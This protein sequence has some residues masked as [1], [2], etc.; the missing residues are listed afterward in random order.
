[1]TSELQA[2]AD[3][4]AAAAAA[5]YE[6]ALAAAHRLRAARLAGDAHSLDAYP[7]GQVPLSAL[8]MPAFDRSVHLRCD[9]A[10]LLDGLNQAFRAEFGH[11][12]VVSDSYR[13]LDQQV[14]CTARKGPLCAEPGTSRHGRGVA[15]DLGGA[16][17]AL[18]TE[19]HQWLLDNGP[20]FGWV[21]PTW[22]L[23]TGSKP[24]SWHFEFDGC[25]TS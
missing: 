17:A 8:C 5:Q 18:G 2:A 19:E 21:K 13:S 1:V 16:G 6:E 9:A 10:E 24:E 4:A 11:D 23:P 20:E 25:P 14:A 12:L 3:E 15:V 22:S 7:N